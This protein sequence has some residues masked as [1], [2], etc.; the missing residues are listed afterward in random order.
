MLIQALRILRPE[1]FA[2]PTRGKREADTPDEPAEPRTEAAKIENKD[3]KLQS[4][5]DSSSSEEVEEL[6]ETPLPETSDGPTPKGKGLEKLEEKELQPLADPEVRRQKR[7]WSSDGYREP[8][9]I[10]KILNTQRTPINP[11]L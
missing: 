4:G 1:K 8:S 9:P 7:S 2:T 3:E 10:E 5:A 11:T 6:A